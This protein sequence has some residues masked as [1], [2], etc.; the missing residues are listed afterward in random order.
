MSK[1]TRKNND[2]ANVLHQKSHWKTSLC[3]CNEKYSKP[4]RFISP[5]GFTN[6]ALRCTGPKN[7]PKSKN[8]SVSGR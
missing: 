4:I 1:R 7:A 3:S 6:Y 2:E 5:A 8:E